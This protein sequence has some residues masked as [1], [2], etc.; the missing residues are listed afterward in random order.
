MNE[1]RHSFLCCWLVA[2]PCPTLCDPMDCSLQAPLTVGF[3]RQEYW[4]GLPFSSPR[5]LPHLDIEP[6]SPALAGGYLSSNQDELILGVLS[7]LQGSI[8]IEIPPISPVFSYSRLSTPTSKFAGKFLC[9][10][11]CNRQM[12]WSQWIMFTSTSTAVFHM[13]ELNTAR[14]SHL[15]PLSVKVLRTKEMNY[16]EHPLTKLP[17]LNKIQQLSIFPS[18]SRQLPLHPLNCLLWGPEN[19]GT[20]WQRILA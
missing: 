12:S 8:R 16:L 3:S 13:A 15:N 20:K 9:P 14:A 10:S 4:S 18:A 19:N 6:V 2:K 17:S 1:W 5:D 7:S 11:Q